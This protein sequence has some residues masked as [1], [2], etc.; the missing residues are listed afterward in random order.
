MSVK[1]SKNN[2]KLGII[3]SI[4]L[5]PI[6]SCREGCPCAADCYAMKG[7]FRFQNV[8]DNMNS[9]Y[10]SYIADPDGYFED[11]KREIDNG[12][13]VYSYF[14]WH[15]AGDIVDARYLE[16]MVEVATQ[17]GRTS[18]LAFTKKYELVNEYIENG[19]SIPDNLHIVF[20][21]WGEA[22]KL[23]NPYNFPVAYVRFKD[24]A[25]NKSIPES[26]SECSGKCSTCLQC[27]HLG[28]GESVVFNRH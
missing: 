12:M 20:S 9:N 6:V 4:N 2:S 5:T 14:R 11:I 15:S 8:R 28:K 16:G 18:F 1:I 19:G 10:M 23:E 24:D 21:A 17:L 26:A 25:Q 7:R 3:P 22:L 13:V 27:W